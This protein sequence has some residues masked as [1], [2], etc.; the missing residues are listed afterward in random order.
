MAIVLVCEGPDDNRTLRAMIPSALHESCD[1]LEAVHCGF[2][3]LTESDEYLA[4]SSVDAA[5]RACF[6]GNFG[7]SHMGKFDGASA[8]PYAPT[9]RKALRVLKSRFSD[10]DGFVLV[11]DEDVH[12]SHRL[13][14][15]RQ[16]RNAS[17]LAHRTAVG[18]ACPKIEAWILSGF[19]AQT[20]A[21]DVALRTEIEALT[22]DPTREPH[23]IRSQASG[24][25]RNIKRVLEVLTQGDHESEAAA[26]ANID[27]ICRNGRE[28]GAVEFIQECKDRLAPLFGAPSGRH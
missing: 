20:T 22:F 11:C 8:L 25:L 5:H 13:E 7:M 23:R 15:L 28:T 21:E 24:D 27:K 19:E 16:A 17:T 18:V 4:W 3:G 6:P 12:D 2:Q 10:S 1:W 9:A 26:S 14:G